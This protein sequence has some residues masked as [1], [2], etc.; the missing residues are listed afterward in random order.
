MPQ[1]YV[2]LGV[3]C[4]LTLAATANTL[5]SKTIQEQTEPGKDPKI[6]VMELFGTK[7]VDLLTDKKNY[8]TPAFIIL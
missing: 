8:T 3:A 1:H 4:L 2:L 5:I 7:V 6:I